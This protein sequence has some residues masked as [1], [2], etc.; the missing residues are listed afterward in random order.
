MCVTFLQLAHVCIFQAVAHELTLREL[1][2]RMSRQQLQH[3]L[4]SWR[5]PHPFYGELAIVISDPATLDWAW[6]FRML[7]ETVSPDASL[8]V[9]AH[10]G[11]HGEAVLAWG[12]LGRL[13]LP[14]SCAENL[15]AHCVDVHCVVDCVYS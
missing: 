15:A 2:S 9:S 14:T 4:G 10:H 3:C 12:K 6:D 8:V 5:S 11:M 7:L 1:A 13:G